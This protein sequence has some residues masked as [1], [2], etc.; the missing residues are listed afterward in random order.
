MR[1]ALAVAEAP[2]ASGGASGLSDAEAARLLG[3]RRTT[4]RH[5]GLTFPSRDALVKWASECAPGTLVELV[6][7]DQR[8]HSRA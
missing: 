2:A 4:L 1:G 6:D 8:L 3:V 7:L 5:A